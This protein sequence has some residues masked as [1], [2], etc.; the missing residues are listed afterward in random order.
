[1]TTEIKIHT[2]LPMGVAGAL[3]QLIGTAWP[4]SKVITEGH[5]A[6]NNLVIEI[7]DSKPAKKVTKREAAKIRKE[8]ESD[9]EFDADFL[10]FNGETLR[11]APPEE[12]CKAV[13]A[14]GLQILEAF[15]QPDNYVEWEVHD[16]ERKTSGVL[17]IAHSKGQT[18][19]VLRKKAEARVAE[20]EGIVAHI[21]DRF[22][23][24]DVDLEEPG[25]ARDIMDMDLI[26]DLRK[27]VSTPATP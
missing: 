20:L 13:G 25:Q 17:S 19:N 14:V 3:L 6:Y 21:Q 7:E 1:M 10:G 23:E 11:S 18:P 9:G 16:R 27:I 2:P 22:A 4:D 12:L 5:F 24:Y 26:G 8:A 15:D